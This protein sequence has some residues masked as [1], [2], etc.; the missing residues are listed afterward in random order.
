MT[1]LPLQQHLL[2]SIS[3]ALLVVEADLSVSF[4]NAAAEAT[5]QVSRQ[6]VVGLQVTQL[7]SEPGSTAENLLSAI[8]SNTPFTKRETE[9]ELTTGD[10]ITVDYAV[11]PFHYQ[12]SGQ[13]SLTV[14]ITPIDRKLQISREEGLLSSQQ[15]TSALVRGLA[16]EIKNPLGGLR[17]AAQ[18]LER[19]LSKALPDQGLQD[20]TNIIIEEADRLR[21]LVDRMLG[22]PQPQ[23]PG[24][25]NIHEVLQHVA[26]LVT[27]ET[28]GVVNIR[29]DYDPSIPEIT[30]DS[31][32]LI[33]AI[34]NIVRNAIEAN[35][36]RL[37]D[38]VIS[39]KSRTQ[40]KFTIGNTLHRL[41]CRLD[42]SDNGPGI[43]RELQNTVFFPMVSGKP[44]GTG[45][46]LSIAQSIINQHRGLVEFSSQ[47]GNTVFTLYIPLGI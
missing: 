47:P 43:P 36:D 12:E 1:S 29:R 7:F 31:A 46:G 16:H 26:S 42:I 24:P 45:L 32:Q 10:T 34:L 30:G 3:T 19:E 11:T 13:P 8:N 18:L 39:L 15:T 25:L 27:A 33:Q 41:V 17:G 6:R 9:F 35:R 22:P 4:L 21:N 37:E 5:L 40:R 23:N 14:E 2:D 20:Y 28:Q 44:E 38:T